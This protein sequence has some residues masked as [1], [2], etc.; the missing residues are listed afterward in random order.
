MVDGSSND[1]F[2][3]GRKLRIEGNLQEALKIFSEAFKIDASLGEIAA[4]F[5]ERAQT[6]MMMHAIEKEK[7]PWVSDGEYRNLAIG[8][9]RAALDILS[10]TRGIY[11]EVYN[12]NVIGLLSVYDSNHGQA[13]YRQWSKILLSLSVWHKDEGDPKRA[14]EIKSLLCEL[15]VAAVTRFLGLWLRKTEISDIPIEG[16]IGA[17]TNEPGDVFFNAGIWL[18]NK[19]DSQPLTSVLKAITPKAV[20]ACFMFALEECASSEEKTSEIQEE[21]KKIRERA[22]L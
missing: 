2:S 10:Q 22:S 6:W 18:R 16:L 14:Q 9:W 3:A 13:L 4:A 15:D 8:C 12:S 20:E 11:P 17:N 7:T 5:D 21:L 1:I 19:V